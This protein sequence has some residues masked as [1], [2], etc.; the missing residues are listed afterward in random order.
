MADSDLL[1]LGNATCADFEEGA[2]VDATVNDA[3]QY[4]E[5]NS[6]GL[7]DQDMGVILGAATSTAVPVL[8]IRGAG[9][10]GDDDD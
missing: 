3:L 9:V 2:S 10:V 1:A 4:A 8:R 5:N 7:D 6:D